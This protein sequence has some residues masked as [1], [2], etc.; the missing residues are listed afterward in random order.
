M[1]LVPPSGTTAAQRVRGGQLQWV[2]AD[3][4]SSVASCTCV[5]G[6][7]L[8][9][10]GACVPCGEGLICS[11]VGRVQLQPGYFA[12]ADDL[13]SVWR[14][15]GVDPGRCPGGAPGLCARLRD[16][17]SIAC[18]ECEPNARWTTDGPCETLSAVRRV[19]LASRVPRCSSLPVLRLLRGRQRES[20]TK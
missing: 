3:G 6:A 1:T 9:E 19:R 16:N 14:C 20:S 10:R 8:S 15:H 17:S 11:L 18:G 5:E 7:R 12:A 4:S 2:D 13:G